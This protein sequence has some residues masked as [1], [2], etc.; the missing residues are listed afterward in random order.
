M[1]KSNFYDYN[2]D[3]VF[4]TQNVVIPQLQEWQ[5]EIVQQEQRYN[6]VTIKYSNSQIMP[7]LHCIELIKIMQTY[8]NNC[9]EDLR[10]FFPK[11]QTLYSLSLDKSNAIYC[12]LNIEFENIVNYNISV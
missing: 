4:I 10:I 8:S 9:D 11:Q 3:Y 6:T 1:L 7:F 12:N 5:K 2:D